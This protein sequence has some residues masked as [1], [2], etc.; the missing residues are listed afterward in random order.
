MNVL[1]LG[2]NRETD[3]FMP[4][5]WACKELERRFP[6]CEFRFYKR[7]EETLDDMLWADAVTGHPSRAMLREAA[8]IK[9]LHI[10]SAGVDAYTDKSIYGNPDIVVTRTA[11]VFSVAIAEHAIGM[12]L[13]LNRLFPKYIRLQADHK[14]DRGGEKYEVAGSTVLMIGTGSL[15]SEIVKRLKSFDCRIAGVRRDTGKKAEGYDAVYPAEKLRDAL[16][17]A[18]YIISTLPIT[19]DTV[20]YLGAEEFAVMKP[21]AIVINVG[22]GGTI[23]TGAL[24]E[25]LSSGRIAGAGLDVTDPEPLNEDSP[26]W[27]MKNVIITPHSSGFSQNTDKRRFECFAGLLEKFIAGEPLDYTVDFD[28]G[29]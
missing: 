21:R 24:I 12:M 23:D 28:H 17:D 25:A 18:D 20:K 16:R 5:G 22:R 11:D 13:A 8:N 6:Q 26:L 7:G 15:A 29:Y 3:L 9:W 1:V 2:Y 10:Q 4:G 14:W 27:D 19:P